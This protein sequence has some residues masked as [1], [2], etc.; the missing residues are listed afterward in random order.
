MTV[1]WGKGNNQTFG[2]LLDTGSKWT[3]IPG[4]P[5]HHCDPPVRVR[6]YGD[7]VI[8]GVLVQVHLTEGLQ[9][10]PVVISPINNGNIHTLLST[11]RTPI[12]SLTYAVQAI[13]VGKAK[14][15][16][17]ELP[18]LRKIVNQN[19]YHITGGIEEICT[20]IKDLKYA[21]VV[22]PAIF[23]FNLPIWSVQKAGGTW[24][25][26]MDYGKLNQVVT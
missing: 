20:N 5:K 4:D 11:G 24:G 22:I 17:L 15:K 6:T 1:H 16:A 19:Q 3:L 18:L 26:T 25:I 13:I 14:W 10:Y 23:A 8:N 7:K 12:S 2:G 21:G 9:M